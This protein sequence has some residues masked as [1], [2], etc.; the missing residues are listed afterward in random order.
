MDAEQASP[1]PSSVR[2]TTTQ[3]HASTSPTTD[4]PEPTVPATKLRQ[5]SITTTYVGTEPPRNKTNAIGQH[6]AKYGPKCTAKYA[7]KR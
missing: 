7:N 2:P 5:L 3:Q 1:Q 4:G 6:R